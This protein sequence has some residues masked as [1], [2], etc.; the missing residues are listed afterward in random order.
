MPSDW[1]ISIICPVF[2]KGDRGERSLL[3]IAYKILAS[4]LSERLKPHVISIVGPYQCG[5][6]PGKSTTDQLFTLRQILEKTQER[7]IPTY[8][9]FIDFKQ[10][11]D[12]PTK[13]ELYRAMNNFGIPSKL[14]KLCQ[15]TLRD[16]WSC[17]RAAG[18]TSNNFQTV[19]GFRQG[20]SL[21]C[22]FF[23]ILLGMIMRAANIETANMISN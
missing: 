16:T 3:N 1:N 15:M 22:S 12:T 19:R 10:A 13:D 5:F 8:H 9:L 14:I 6:M 18:G 17:V 4:I 7:Q 11:Y 20:D 2:K 21:S 23:N